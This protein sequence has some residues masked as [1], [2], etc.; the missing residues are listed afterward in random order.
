MLFMQVKVSPRLHVFSLTENEGRK[1][2]PALWVE[3]M[4]ERSLP[5]SEPKSD[6]MGLRLCTG[7]A[8]ETCLLDDR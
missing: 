8:T 1:G 7:K 5:N 6:P 2:T 4:V 3:M